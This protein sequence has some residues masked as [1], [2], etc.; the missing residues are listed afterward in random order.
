MRGAAQAQLSAGGR[1]KA[2]VTNP[3][4]R[5]APGIHT[6]LRA[7][8]PVLRCLS[9]P[10]PPKSQRSQLPAC[11]A[12]CGV[13]RAQGYTA[14]YDTQATPMPPR[15]NVADSIR[16][17]R[18]ALSCPPHRSIHN[19]SQ[20]DGSNTQRSSRGALKHRCTAAQGALTDGC[21][22]ALTTRPTPR[23]A[24]WTANVR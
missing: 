5:C 15:R 23:V 9:W 17:H 24:L 8:Q 4:S 3:A 22:V 13:L 1:R 11:S 14:I 12:N 7:C 20:P 6:P 18:H 2:R 16:W 10:R 19:E 21:G